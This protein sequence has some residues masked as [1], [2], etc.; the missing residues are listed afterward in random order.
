MSAVVQDN[1]CVYGGYAIFK[2]WIEVVLSYDNNHIK[3]QIIGDDQALQRLF[4]MCWQST[5]SLSHLYIKE[6]RLEDCKRLKN[7]LQVPKLCWIVFTSKF[8]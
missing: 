5:P 7:N 3:Q 4:L 8:T 6:W 2:E 1:S